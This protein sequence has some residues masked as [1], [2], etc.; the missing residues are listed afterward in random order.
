MDSPE[1]TLALEA[2]Y[3]LNDKPYTNF[4]FQIIPLK[5]E[6]MMNLATYN[7]TYISLSSIK[8]R[9]RHFYHHV[10]AISHSEVV[11][12]YVPESICDNGEITFF[13]AGTN[14]MLGLEVKV[15]R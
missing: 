15:T 12:N 14:K 10:F 8:G 1:S 2:R 11:V 13:W 5:S 6:W 9:R 4:A 7:K 3:D